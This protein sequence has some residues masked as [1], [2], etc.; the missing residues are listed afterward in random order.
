MTSAVFPFCAT[1]WSDEMQELTIREAKAK[2][3]TTLA[4]SYFLLSTLS[5]DYA[6]VCVCLPV[7]PLSK[8]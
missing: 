8:V 1:S 2:L 7:S 3:V 4:N 6:I 5:S